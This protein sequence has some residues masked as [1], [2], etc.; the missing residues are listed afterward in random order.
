SSLKVKRPADIYTHRIYIITTPEI[1]QKKRRAVEKFVKSFEEACNLI[2]TDPKTAKEIIKSTFPPQEQSMNA[3]WDKVDFSLK[4]DYDKMKALIL[5][6]GEILFHLGL[7][8]KDGS[9]NPRHLKPEDV[10]Y[11]FNHDFKLPESAS[12]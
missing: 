6:D 7:A 4:F 5:E 9:G 10:Q 11:F 3:L 1:L 12:H 8:P 2:K